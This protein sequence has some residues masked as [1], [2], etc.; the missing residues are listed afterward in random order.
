MLKWAWSAATQRCFEL[1]FPHKT[2][3]T[4]NCKLCLDTRTF[5]ML[6]GYKKLPKSV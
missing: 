1:L 5:W 3:L 2:M 6:K 4:V